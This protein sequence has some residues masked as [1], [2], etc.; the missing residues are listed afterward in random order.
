MKKIDD[1]LV[2]T[3]FILQKHKLLRLKAI[4]ALQN[5]P[6]CDAIRELIDGYINHHSIILASEAF[7]D[8]LQEKGNE[9]EAKQSQL[10]E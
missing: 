2:Q 1:E 9:N 5:R 8:D 3:A 6:M 4:C 10:H 7:P